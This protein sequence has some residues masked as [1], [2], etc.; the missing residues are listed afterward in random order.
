MTTIQQ[1]IAT[2]RFRYTD[3]TDDIIYV[4][5]CEIE[6]GDV[7]ILAAWRYGTTV[8]EVFPYTVSFPVTIRRMIEIAAKEQAMCPPATPVELPTDWDDLEVLD[9]EN[10]YTVAIKAALPEIKT[11][12]ER[13]LHGL[14]TV[15]RVECL[16]GESTNGAVKYRIKATGGLEDVRR[17]LHRIRLF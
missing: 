13:R 17:E 16:A 2:T 8:E 5:E 12:S 15:C 6:D 7:T 10:T 11:D 1:P 9:V 3:P 4:G 14:S